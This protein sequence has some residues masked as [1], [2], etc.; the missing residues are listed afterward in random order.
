MPGVRRRKIRLGHPRMREV[1]G[2]SV[3]PVA[4][5]PGDKRAG[6]RVEG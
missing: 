2:R 4:T 5:Q 3:A 1:L 6:G